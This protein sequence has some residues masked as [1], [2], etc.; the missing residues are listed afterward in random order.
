VCH[1]LRTPTTH[2]LDVLLGLLD[3]SVEVAAT[4]CI[5]G[6]PPT[7][8]GLPIPLLHSGSVCRLG[9]AP[10]CVSVPHRRP[11]AGGSALVRGT[12]PAPA[13]LNHSED[14]DAGHHVPHVDLTR[15][16]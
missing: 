3:R 9:A 14:A 12:V 1:L 13:K 16:L 7:G 6:A 11:V 4:D 10:A 15:R 8:G 5:V 2:D